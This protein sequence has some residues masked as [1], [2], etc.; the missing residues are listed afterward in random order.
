[1]GDEFV[2]AA[3]DIA[4]DAA[5]DYAK[6]SPHLAHPRLRAEIEGRLRRL[7][8]DL[9]AR[10]G[11][12]R[13]LEVGAGHGTFTQLLL[14]AG[15]EVVVTEVSSASADHLRRVFA[16]DDRVE[17][18]HDES[19]DDILRGEEEWDAAVM[20]SVLHHIP[21]YL[22]FLDRLQGH[23]SSGGAI[24]T[25]QDPLWYPRRTRPS[26]WASRGSYFVW[27]L[28]Q[29]SYRQ[30]LATRLRRL[31][32]V[33]DHTAPSDLVEYH[34]MRQ[35]VDEEAI[36][37]LLAEQFDVEVFCY[38]SSQGAFFHRAFEHTR[39]RSDFGVVATGHRRRPARRRGGAPVSSVTATAASSCSR[40]P[41]RP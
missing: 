19:G 34:V 15:A 41:R 40:H 14:D 25:A 1:M 5:H 36:R 32:R 39:L 37:L 9:I 22:A 33:Y 27:R 26:H 23:I 31:R 30:G 12:C 4:H 6:G 24:F 20:I 29:G 10:N 16:G 13:V 38:W 11:S 28:A 35:G 8:R 2:T 18:R 7:V 21:D 17:V 3:Q